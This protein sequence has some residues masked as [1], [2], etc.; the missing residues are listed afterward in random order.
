M[1][2]KVAIVF[3][4]QGS[5]SIGMLNNLYKEHQVTIKQIFEEASDSLGYDLWDLIQNGPVEKLNQT[6]FTQPALIATEVAMWRIWMKQGVFKPLILAGH[7]LGEYTALVCAE[8][9]S[10][11][12]AL[13][14]VRKRGQL[15]QDTVVAGGAAMTA[16][17]GLSDEDVVA[18]C[19]AAS[20]VSGHIVQAANFNA[21]G[22]VVIAGITAAVNS[23][24][25]LAKEKGAKRAILLQVSVLSHC[26]LMKPL[27]EK[28]FIELKSINWCMPKIPVVHNF[29][30]KI[31]RKIEDI[32]NS[33]EKQLYNPVRWTEV[34]QYIANMEINFILECG[35]GKVLTGLN[36][37]INKGLQYI[38]F[39]EKNSILLEKLIA[40]KV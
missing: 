30:V 25:D 34:I 14:L 16:I 13:L 31:H 9:L 2:P 40:E 24:I 37:R 3:P 38:A 17:M 6:E 27:A 22:Q 20:I 39:E 32:Y 4:G 8:A 19:K 23:A 12:D 11:K 7:S 35:P 28:F 15:M 18:I 5:Q 26:I 21:P 29:D 10:L 1:D 33:L 36:K